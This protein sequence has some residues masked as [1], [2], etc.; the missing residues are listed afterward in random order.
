MATEQPAPAEDLTGRARIRDAALRVFAEQG[1]KGATVQL[2]AAAAGVST[3][4]IRHHFGSKDGLRR[5]CDE[6]AIG[7]LL[8]QA[9][10]ALDEDT[11]APGFL[12]SMYRASGAGTRYLARALVEGSPAAAELFDTGAALAERFLSDHDPDRFPPGAAATR[13]AA[14]VMGAMQLSTLALHTH[15]GRR[16]GVDPLDPAHAPRLVAAM[17]GVSSAMAAFLSGERGRPISDASPTPH[18]ERP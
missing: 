5:A 11:A 10:R 15:I 14:A 3:G 13:D 12:D 18:E 9:R 16:M 17:V 4:L 1:V 2:I 8:H 6:Y 7:T